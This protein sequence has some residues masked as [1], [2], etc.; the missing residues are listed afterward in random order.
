MTP[1]KRVDENS[2][3]LP[4]KYFNIFYFWKLTILKRKICKNPYLVKNDEIKTGRNAPQKIGEFEQFKFVWYA[5]KKCKNCWIL[6]MFPV[7]K[8][9]IAGE[10]GEAP[11]KSVVGNILDF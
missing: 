6:Y 9:I 3:I 4:Q 1:G 2:K 11:W 8:M 5:I 10:W 7:Y